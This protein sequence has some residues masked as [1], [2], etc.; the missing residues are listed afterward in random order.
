MFRKKSPRPGFGMRWAPPTAEHMIATIEAVLADDD[1]RLSIE[2]QIR[3]AV[4]SD[5]YLYVSAA[6]LNPDRVLVAVF[7]V[8]SAIGCM[9]FDASTG[10]ILMNTEWTN[11]C[12]FDVSQSPSTRF[13]TVGIVTYAGAIPIADRLRSGDSLRPDERFGAYFYISRS[14]TFCDAARQRLA[15]FGIPASMHKVPPVL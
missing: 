11:F 6:F 15:D 4:R 5:E 3:D 14:P 12:R 13:D 10:E 9:I 7:V 1:Y 8:A 2:D